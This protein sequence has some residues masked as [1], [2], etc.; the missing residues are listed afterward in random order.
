MNDFR[1]RIH[2]HISRPSLYTL[3]FVGVVALGYA[4]QAYYL[5]VL[6]TLDEVGASAT[7]LVTANTIFSKDHPPFPTSTPPSVFTPDRSLAPGEKSKEVLELQKF[8]V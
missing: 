4:G 6:A 2:S 5:T 7:P 8:L 1:S 3:L